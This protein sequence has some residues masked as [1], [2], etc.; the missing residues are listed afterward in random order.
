MNN[1]AMQRNTDF[2]VESSEDIR[3][4]Y[5]KEKKDRFKIHI[6]DRSFVTTLHVRSKNS[7]QENK[8]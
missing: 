7:E 4:T 3:I 1:Q 6:K 8:K 5:Y 2:S